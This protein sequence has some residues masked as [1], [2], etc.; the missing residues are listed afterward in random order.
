VLDGSCPLDAPPHEE[1]A[2]TL[3]MD[4]WRGLRSRPVAPVPGSAAF[5]EGGM[6]VLRGGGAHLVVRCG[7]VGQNGNGGHA[8]ND[9][10]SYELAYVDPL[11]TDSGTY[12][13]TGDPAARNIFRSTRAHNGVMIADEEINHMDPAGLFRMEQHGTPTL[14]A[15]EED[16]E[17]KVLEVSH[18]GYLRLAVPTIHKRRFT[19]DT[20]S[21]RLE[22]ADE[23]LGEDGQWGVSAVHLVPG[24]QVERLSD[25]VFLLRRGSTCVELSFEGAVDRVE[26]RD[27]WVSDRYGI[28]ELAPVIEAYVSGP[29]PLRFGYTLEPPQVNRAALQA[30]HGP[31]RDA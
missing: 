16:G 23:L 28:R 21:A 20:A 17:H 27:D 8:H 24:T 4:A 5:P 6:Y 1:V 31:A 3:G 30:A 19:L 29:L 22:V 7:G 12:A 9:A 13:Y 2:W 18:D 25:G 10:M 11:V 26:V 15:F 14:G